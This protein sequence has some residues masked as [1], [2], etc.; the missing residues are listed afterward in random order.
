M[1]DEKTKVFLKDMGLIRY[2][3][4]EEE[5]AQKIMEIESL[6]EEKD[7]GK[8]YFLKVANKGLVVDLFFSDKKLW[9]ECYQF[10]HK[11][12]NEGLNA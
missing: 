10:V 5:I 2:S 8:K 7:S 3:N 11:K 6:K 1:I 4:I 9:E 12:F